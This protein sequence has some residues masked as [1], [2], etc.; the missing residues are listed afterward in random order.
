MGFINW[1]DYQLRIWKK[2]DYITWTDTL[3]TKLQGSDKVV[4]L[5]PDPRV[6]LWHIKSMEKQLS[7]WKPNDDEGDDTTFSPPS[8]NL[9]DILM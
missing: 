6:A 8:D 9:Y 3:H 4:G 1:P 5:K 2:C 7:R